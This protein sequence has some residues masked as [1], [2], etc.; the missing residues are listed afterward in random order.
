MIMVIIIAIII[1]ILKSE[2]L[3][4]FSNK[5][6][7]SLFCPSSVYFCTLVYKV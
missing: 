2:I 6:Y 5:D 7:C 1:V 3:P 4:C